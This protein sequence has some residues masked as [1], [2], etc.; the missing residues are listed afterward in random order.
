[1]VTYLVYEA[2]RDVLRT[3]RNWWWAEVY[4]MYINTVCRT[5]HEFCR[6]RLSHGFIAPRPLYTGPLCPT[7]E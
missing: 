1:M 2:L 3:G 7:L 5:G 6:C 4:R